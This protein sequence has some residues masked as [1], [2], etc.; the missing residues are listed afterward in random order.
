M[1]MVKSTMKVMAGHFYIY[2]NVNIVHYKIMYNRLIYIILTICV[3][4]IW[5]SYCIYVI[6]SYVIHAQ[7]MTIFC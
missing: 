6:L 7:N 2:N 4:I 1:V 5:V 3:V